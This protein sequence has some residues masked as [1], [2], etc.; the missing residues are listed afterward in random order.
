LLISGKN[1]KPT[2]QVR[3]DEWARDGEESPCRI[4][5]LSPFASLK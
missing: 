5:K 1:R 2:K 4:G 3:L